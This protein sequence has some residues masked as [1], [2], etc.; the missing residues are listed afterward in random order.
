M[1]WVSETLCAT[2]T[3]G[4]RG[5]AAGDPGCGRLVLGQGRGLAPAY[6]SSH[7]RRRGRLISR[8]LPSR[9]SAKPGSPTVRMAAGLTSRRYS[10]RVPAP[11]LCGE[12]GDIP[13]LAG[14]TT[15]AAP[16]YPPHVHYVHSPHRP[17]RRRR[18]RGSA[19]EGRWRRTSYPGPRCWPPRRR[20][21]TSA[22]TSPP[23]RSGPASRQ[24]AAR[25]RRRSRT[26]GPAAERAQARRRPGNLTAGLQRSS[27]ARP[28][29]HP[30]RKEG[31]S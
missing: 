20:K 25:R 27:A 15:P 9:S 5:A 24:K 14:R 29:G 30:V 10:H 26:A 11:T 1:R 31:R 7:H 21:P 23:R 18:E 4:Q 19:S 6:P 22:S 8:R 16:R 13:T 3:P 28:A 2:P 17:R 12:V